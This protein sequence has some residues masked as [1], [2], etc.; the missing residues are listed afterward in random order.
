MDEKWVE[1]FKYGD[2]LGIQ[3]SLNSTTFL[4]RRSTAKMQGSDE[5]VHPVGVTGV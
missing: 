3:K 2:A 5:E 4:V 1:R